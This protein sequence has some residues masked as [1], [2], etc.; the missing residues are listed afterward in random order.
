M[1]LLNSKF[2]KLLL[3]ILN[4]L[5]VFQRAGKLSQVFSESLIFKGKVINFSLLL[6]QVICDTF[7]FRKEVELRLDSMVFFIQEINLIL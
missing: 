2:V 6:L 1:P 7:V 5:E 3:A 4:L